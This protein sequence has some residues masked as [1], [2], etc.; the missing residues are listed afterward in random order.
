M[1]QI[2]KKTEQIVAPFFKNG[3]TLD[4]YTITFP[5]ADLT[6]KLDA[7][8]DNYSGNAARSPVV[9]ALEAVQARASIEII[10]TPRFSGG[11]TTLTIALAA[12][13]GGYPTDNYDGAAGTE[14]FAAYMQ[15]LIVAASPSNY[16][17]QGFDLTNATVA[18]N[19][20]GVAL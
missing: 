17:Y 7:D 16:T 1:A 4:F 20:R 12:I 3:V 13:G 9:V 19:V 18:A 14:T 11:N 10:G 5:S 2:P 15:A 6:A 8:I